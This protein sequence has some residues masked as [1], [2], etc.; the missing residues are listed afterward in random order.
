MNIEATRVKYPSKKIVAIFKPDRFSRGARFA[1]QFAQA[2]DLADYPYF[3][4]FPEN[5]V[6]EDGITY[7]DFFIVIT[8]SSSLYISLLDINKKTTSSY[9]ANSS[10]AS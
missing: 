1:V 2:M 5:A 4:P 10:A 9:L 6:K 8:F 7:I 3:C